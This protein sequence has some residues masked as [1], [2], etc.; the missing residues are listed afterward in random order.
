MEHP[1][2]KKLLI[3][4]EMTV[5][6]DHLP[7]NSASI[8][9]ELSDNIK[10][11]FS[12][13]HPYD[14][15]ISFVKSKNE[16]VDRLTALKDSIRP[17][18]IIWVAYPKKTSGIQTD[19]S[20]MASWEETE[21]FNLTPCASASINEVWTGIRLKPKD[22]V[23]STGL[24]NESIK[25]NAYGEFIDVENKRIRLPEDLKNTLG[26]HPIAYEFFEQLSWSNKKEYILWIL[27]AKQDKTR[28]SRIEKMMELLA[29]KKKNPADK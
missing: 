18:T 28:I 17:S 5:L 11:V 13:D 14:V 16:L 24:A 3:K 26:D 12:L 22:Q 20:M 15:V 6:L 8:L 7:E 29:L 4:P 2:L 9:Y 10:K 21:E 23:K 19:L 27:S 1:V 25:N